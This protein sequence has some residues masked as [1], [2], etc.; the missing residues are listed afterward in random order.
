MDRPFDWTVRFIGAIPAAV[1]LPDRLTA[2]ADLHQFTRRLHEILSDPDPE[3]RS[4]TVFALNLDNFR[5]LNTLH[6][7]RVGDE[8]LKIIAE[9]L[10][11]G[12]RSRHLGAVGARAGG[13]HTVA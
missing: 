5:T 7:F 10:V 12:T 4:V 1:A 9:R 11:S 3:R 6:G 2:L 13:R 8:A